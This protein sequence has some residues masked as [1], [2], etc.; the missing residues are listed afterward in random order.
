MAR[1]SSYVTDTDVRGTDKVLG[2]DTGGATKNY[3]IDSIGEYLTKNNVI[4]VAGQLAFV[5]EAAIADAGFGEFFINDGNDGDETA[6]NAITKMHIS[7]QYASG[8]SLD[9]MLDEIIDNK[10]IIVQA[11][12]Q[13]IKAIMTVESFSD[14]ATQA[15]FTDVT[16]TVS[17]ASGNLTDGAVYLISKYGGGSGD[18]DKAYTHTPSTASSTWTVAH[19]LGKKPSVSIVDSSDNLIRGQVDYTDLNNLT[20][21]LSAPT[22]GKAY[23]N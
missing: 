2:S 6:L 10:F 14:D 15:G 4:T 18:G 19:S 23:L 11:R 8:E 9:E 22:S 13:N 17:E 7:T 1:V 16:V 12:N 20:I 21:T 3:T 5:F